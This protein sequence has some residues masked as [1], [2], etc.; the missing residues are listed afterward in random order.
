MHYKKQLKSTSYVSYLFSIS[1]YSTSKEMPPFKVL[2]Q[3][4]DDMN[5][6]LQMFTHIYNTIQYIVFKLNDRIANLPRPRAATS[7]ATR[8]GALPD[9]N[10]ATKIANLYRQMIKQLT[11][12]NCP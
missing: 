11:Q 5:C 9:R 12:L 8:I 3:S 7:V 6:P 10:S 1:I 2:C 4:G